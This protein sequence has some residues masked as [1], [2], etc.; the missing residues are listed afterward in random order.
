MIVM[1]GLMKA[2]LNNIVEPESDVSILLNNIVDN[3]EHCGQH[4]I[5]QLYFHQF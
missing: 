5:I 4:S 3:I 1:A 2:E